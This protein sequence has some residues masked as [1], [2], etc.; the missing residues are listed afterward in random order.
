[1]G[2]WGDGEIGGRESCRFDRNLVSSRLEMSCYSLQTTC[3]HNQLITLEVRPVANL[4][5]NGKSA[6]N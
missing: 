3:Y 2:R 4:I 1:M 5:L 6:P